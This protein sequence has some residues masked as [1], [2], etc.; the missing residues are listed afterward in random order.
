MHLFIEKYVTTDDRDATALDLLYAADMKEPA[1]SRTKFVAT[2]D[3][4]E[5]AKVIPCAEYSMLLI[6]H[7][8]FLIQISLPPPSPALGL[9]AQTISPLTL[10]RRRLSATP[11]PPLVPQYSRETH[12]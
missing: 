1:N 8:L 2:S 12:G 6:R 7:F 11:T 9:P 4:P 5:S 10:S 3:P